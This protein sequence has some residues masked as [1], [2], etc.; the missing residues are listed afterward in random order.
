MRLHSALAA[1]LLA[2]TL[3][4]AALLAVALA[5]AALA[6]PAPPQITVYGVV[7]GTCATATGADTLTSDPPGTPD[8]ALTLCWPEPPRSVTAT[9]PGGVATWPSAAPTPLP[10]RETP[11]SAPVEYRARQI[12]IPM[13]NGSEGR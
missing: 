2:L 10:T 11:T 9:G 6:Q 4:S 7:G 8:G 13:L 1:I 3:I 12:L 5:G